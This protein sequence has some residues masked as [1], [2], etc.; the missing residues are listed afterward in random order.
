MIKCEQ[1]RCRCN[2][3]YYG[4]HVCTGE[5]SFIVVPTTRSFVLKCNT[6]KKHPPGRACENVGPG[7]DGLYPGQL[8]VPI[9]RSNE[10]TEPEESAVVEEACLE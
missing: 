7:M 5:P 8:K 2:A 10:D 9:D 4:H 3:I 1:S 6:Y